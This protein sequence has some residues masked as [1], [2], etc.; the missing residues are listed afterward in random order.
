MYRSLWRRLGKAFTLIELLVVIAIIA[1]LAGMLLPALAAARE[2]ARRTSCMNN[3]KQFAVALE[4]YTGDYAGFLPQW[5]GSDSD[6]WGHNAGGA[7]PWNDP[8]NPSTGQVDYLESPYRQ[9]TSKEEPGVKCNHQEVDPYLCHTWTWTTASRLSTR[10]L[11]KGIYT[12]PAVPTGNDEVRVGN[13]GMPCCHLTY[14]RAI[15]T[16][17]NPGLWPGSAWED[18]N[19]AT[20]DLQHAPTGLGFLLTG[21]Y[22]PDAKSYYCP[23]TTALPGS[24]SNSQN[25]GWT[26]G[27]WQA[28]G[29][30]DANTLHYG[31]FP[32]DPNEDW[33]WAGTSTLWSDYA[34]RGAPL[35][36]DIPWCASHEFYDPRV[37][38]MYTKPAQPLRFGAA[39]FR[40]RKEL[41][42][43]AIVSD[44]FDKVFQ[45]SD[46]LKADP[47][48][49]YA[50]D[51]LGTE[52]DYGAPAPETHPGMG[53]TAH[54]VGYNVLYGDGHAKWVGDP[55]QKIIWSD[56]A[57]GTWG[58]APQSMWYG[59]Y[60]LG[61]NV[62]WNPEY[63]HGPFAWSNSYGFPEGRSTPPTDDWVGFD[64]TSVGIWHFFDT[65]SGI[66]VF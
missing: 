33:Y 8:T 30:F 56:S 16:A 39:V 24:S 7:G 11:I 66:D 51:A 42:D 5:V 3:L 14:Y 32:W 9:C 22:L 15:A 64:E 57:S 41:K 53:I 38:L 58:Q 18:G 20:K 2:K 49:D 27:H 36:V 34:Y 12:G 21:G 23:S 62:Y 19:P 52:Y 28:A 35:L 54:V 48:D 25:Q 60:Q 13:T 46:P 43:R 47:Y 65:A 37:S 17:G 45:R 6:D 44:G 26:Q 63:H 29:G 4:S 31:N 50:I 55:E 61:T 40:T 1:I 10:N 59:E